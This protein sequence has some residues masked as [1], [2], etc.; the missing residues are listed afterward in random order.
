MFPKAGSLFAF[1]VSV[2]GKA[3]L[4]ELVGQYT[5]LGEAPNHSSHL[6]VNVSI[7]YL[8]GKAILFNNP[9]GGKGERY[10]HVFVPVKGGQKVEVLY[11]KVHIFGAGC[12]EYAVPVELQG[13]DVSRLC[14]ELAGVIDEIT[15]GCDSDAVGICLLGAVVDNHSGICDNADF[16]DI[17]YF[18]RGHD[19]HRIGP[20]LSCFI[21]TLT[22]SAKV[23]SECSHSYFRS[24]WVVHEALV[25]TDELPGHAM[26]H[27]HGMMLIVDRRGRR[28]A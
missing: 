3:L 13:G 28:W 23:F 6:Q 8:V 18:L 25:A 15:T 26:N 22:H 16:W 10:A 7:V 4:E 1:V 21:I 24:V 14:H 17:W 11:I 2:W 20:F 19:K 12:A 5:S 9:W 27:G